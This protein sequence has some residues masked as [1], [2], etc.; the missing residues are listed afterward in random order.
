MSWWQV[1]A[2]TLAGGRFVISPL[3]EVLAGLKTLHRGSAAH[4]G[5]QQWLDAHLPGYRDRLARDRVTAALVRAALGRR[6]NATFLTPTPLGDGEAT[7]AQEL[8]QI[9]S[10]P[11]AAVRAD[12][13]ESLNGSLPALLRRDDLADRCADLLEWVW[14]EAVQPSW[15][16][17]RRIVEADIVARTT[18]LG[19]HGWATAL[20]EMRPGMR[21]LGEDRLQTTV[22]DSPPLELSG[23]QLMFVPVTLDQSWV[24]WDVPAVDRPDAPLRYAIVY[25]CSGVLADGDREPAPEALAALLGAARAEIL[26][27]LDA[28][29]TTTQLVA[30]T[31]QPLG[32]VGRHLK[33]LFE[34]R[35]THRRRAGR[36]VLYYLTSA[37]QVLV[38]AQRAGL[39]GP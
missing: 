31:G 3:A 19:V 7:F 13:T 37:G 34:A 39:G 12:L 18:R 23:V 25:P 6:W 8:E 2:D 16:R 30:L 10:T 5:E 1:D 29:K 38:G 11:P 14:S 26:T 28:P 9:R 33:I 22:C 4:I 15:P 21:W 24:C 32:S 20:S 35:L 36:S 27:L 17:R